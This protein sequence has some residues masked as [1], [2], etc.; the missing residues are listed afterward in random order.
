MKFICVLIVIVTFTFLSNAQN[1]TYVR[2][3]IFL[4]ENPLSISKLA[5]LGL[6]FDHG[7]R[8]DN[9]SYTSDFSKTELATIDNAGFKYSIDIE[10]VSNYYVE[11]N[12]KSK[13]DLDFSSL[14]SVS[15]L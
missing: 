2:A 9:Y 7:I 10:D 5:S 1:S 11:R 14:D 3:T 12:I 13:K 15:K 4:D 8:R 6:C